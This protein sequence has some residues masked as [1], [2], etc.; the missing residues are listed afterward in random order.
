MTPAR[1]RRGGALRRLLSVAAPGGGAVLGARAFTRWRGD[2][3]MS[4]LSGGLSDVERVGDTVTGFIAIE[5]RGTALGVVRR[6]EGRI[7]EGG[8]G[9]VLATLKGSRPPTRGWW[10]SNI[11][12]PGESCEAEIAVVLEDEPAA[13]L[14]VELTLQEMGRR[15]FQY[16]TTRVVVPV[17]AMQP[18]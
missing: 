10:V 11:L 17:P 1:E 8:R 12:R 3:H 18:A 15:V 13:R 6:V 5:N 9:V 7:L 2:S 16:R 4:W 14:V